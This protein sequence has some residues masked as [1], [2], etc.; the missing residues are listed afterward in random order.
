MVKAY[1]SKGN[2]LNEI[3]GKNDDILFAVLNEAG[4]RLNASCGGRGTCLKCKVI[5]DD[6]EVLSCKFRIK[7]D[8]NVVVPDY[9]VKPMK[10]FVL[11][12]DDKVRGISDTEENISVGVA[13]DIGTT[14]VAA[15]FYNLDNKELIH[16]ESALNPQAQFGAD[17]ITRIDY[18]MKN[19]E[20]TKKMQSLI[21]DCLKGMFGKYRNISKCVISGNTT[22]L[23]FLVGE[24][25][26]SLAVAPYVPVFTEAR[27]FDNDELGLGIDKVILLPSISAFVGG[28]ITA[29]I[30][31]TKMHE[32]KKN[33]LFIDMGTNGEMVLNK[34]GDLIAA[35]TACGPA[36]E[37]ANIK[38]GMGGI[39]GAIC[40]FEEETDGF[41]Y[42][43]LGDEE[44]RGI[45]GSG[46]IDI[47]AYLLKKE[48]IEDN[49]FM[50]E[51]FIIATGVYIT[52]KD[53][54][55]FQN[56]KAAI[57]AGIRTMAKVAG[58]ELEEIEE[59]RLA[60]GFGSFIDIENAINATLLPY[61]FRGKCK[62]VG[63]T[64]GK[65]ACDVLLDEKMLD[66]CTEVSKKVN[67][68]ELAENKYFSDFFVMS[69]FFESE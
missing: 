67:Y 56:A 4:Y 1:D 14:T 32:S 33:I 7:G 45:C 51:D 16:I 53:V 57:G 58:I 27:I 63:N 2:L 39:A 24:E 43:T 40:K 29:G 49:G 12:T 15:Y 61:E 36:F 37:G 44:A 48:Y 17:V 28:D 41:T 69:M 22:M 8:H 23:H 20:G 60:G 21:I 64:S 19:S 46:L 35:S 25:T 26:R 11:T 54:R 38:C 68:I 18:T 31:S 65:G 55:E 34:G 30:I 5:V 47:I 42:N 3:D 6:E 66:V 10:S 50:E 62:S 9:A 59:V 13:V 52:P